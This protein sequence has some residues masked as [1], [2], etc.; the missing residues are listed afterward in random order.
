[1]IIIII[2][3]FRVELVQSIQQPSAMFLFVL[4]G[5]EDILSINIETI[6]SL[7]HHSIGQGNKDILEE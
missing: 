6:Q 2:E 4:G 3:L 1:M 7:S 5:N